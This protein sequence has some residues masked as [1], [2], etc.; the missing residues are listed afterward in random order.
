MPDLN[1]TRWPQPIVLDRAKD[2]PQTS[3]EFEGQ[4]TTGEAGCANVAIGRAD[5]HIGPRPSSMT[6]V[7]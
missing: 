2:Y 1:L 5:Q 7:L 3:A 4:L 6:S